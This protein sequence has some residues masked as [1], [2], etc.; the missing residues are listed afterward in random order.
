MNCEEGVSAD[1]RAVHEDGV[2]GGAAHELIAGALAHGGHSRRCPWPRSSHIFPVAKQVLSQFALH[3]G[4]EECSAAENRAAAA[5]HGGALAG[6]CCFVHRTLALQLNQVGSRSCL[7][8]LCTLETRRDLL[9]RMALPQLTV[10]P[11]SSPPGPRSQGCSCERPWPRSSRTCPAA[12]SALIEVLSGFALH[13]KC[14][15]MA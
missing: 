1:E 13:L 14:E 4:D 6:G 7:S 5:A 15:Y 10:L 3:F 8:M 2:A 12:E 11:T 9:L